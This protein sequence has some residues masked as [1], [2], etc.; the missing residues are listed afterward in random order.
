MNNEITPEQLQD[1]CLETSKE[2]FGNLMD[3]RLPELARK[4][5][6]IYDKVVTDRRHDFIGNY[7]ICIMMYKLGEA[8]GRSAATKQKALPMRQH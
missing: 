3:R 5:M 6:L 1:L 2:F 4:C 7:V 8:A